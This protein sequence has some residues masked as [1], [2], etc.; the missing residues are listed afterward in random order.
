MN[1]SGRTE[2]NVRGGVIECVILRGGINYNKINLF[3]ECGCIAG[4]VDRCAF[5]W[6]CIDM[7]I[8]D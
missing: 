6:W 8:G 4:C 2:V 7:V 5:K 3:S 1:G